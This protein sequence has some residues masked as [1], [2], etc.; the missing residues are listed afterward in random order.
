M[1]LGKYKQLGAAC[2]FTKIHQT[3]CALTPIHAAAHARCIAPIS[4][5]LKAVLKLKR[6]SSNTGDLT[7]YHYYGAVLQI[8]PVLT[9]I[10]LKKKSEETQGIFCYLLHIFICPAQS[11]N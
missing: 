11:F 8:L 7:F 4:P 2:C 10:N 5:V 6:I 3:Y 9:Y 1:L